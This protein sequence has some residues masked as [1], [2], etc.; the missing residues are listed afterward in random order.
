MRILVIPA[1]MAGCGY[2]RLLWAAEYLQSQGH[3]ILI[4]WPKTGDGLEVRM[5]GDTVIDCN[6]PH[7]AD[8]IV[9]QRVAHA[10]HSQVIKILRSKGVGVV[11]DMDDDLTAIHRKNKAWL[12]YH[13]KSNT[14]YSW[15]NAEQ[16]CR[17]AT[18][19]TVSTSTL[20]KIYAKHGRGMTIPNFVPARYLKI[21]RQPQDPAFGWAGTTQ[22]HPA[23]LK[24]CGKAVQQLLDEGYAFKVVGPPSDVRNELRLTKEPNYTGVVSI[25][26]W[27]NAMAQLDVAMA[28]LEVSAFNHSKS[29]LKIIEAMAVGVPFVASPRTE[30]RR[31][32]A[33]S[34][35]GLLAETPKEWYLKIKQLMD[36]EVMRKELGEAGRAYMQTQTIEANAW[37]HLEAWTRAHEIEQGV[38]AA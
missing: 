35:G 5:V 16:A 37:R 28:P 29:A 32:A 26:A 2:Y 17:D 24:V 15:R 1:D 18:L 30:Y 10:W 36:D 34:G 11:I 20:L 27:A 38:K 7:D 19:V 8:V 6:V 25:H 9:L 12:N 23:D 22:S 13:P 4:Q 21:Q 3:D 31:V 14:P 33:E